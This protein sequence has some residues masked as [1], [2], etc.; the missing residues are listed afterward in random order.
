MSQLAAQVVHNLNLLDVNG[1]T[2]FNLNY[3][4]FFSPRIIISRIDKKIRVF[5]YA[6]LSQE[7]EGVKAL[8][9]SF[10]TAS[11]PA[12]LMTSAIFDGV[13]LSSISNC[14]IEGWPE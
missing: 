6:P 8:S 3:Q 7:S 10:H 4:D 2:K 14:L 13:L 1:S 12:A 9:Q 11:A 5:S